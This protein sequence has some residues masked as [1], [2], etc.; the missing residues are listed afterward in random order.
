LPN[1]TRGR[2]EHH[3]IVIFITSLLLSQNL[4][5]HAIA[6]EVGSWMHTMTG[7]P[8]ELEMANGPNLVTGNRTGRCYRPTR[9][10]FACARGIERAKPSDRES[11]P[12][13][14]WYG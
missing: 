11:S 13:V 12:S 7:R 3:N 1:S 8:S 2:L 5:M 4:C 6:V 10:G 9:P 14:S